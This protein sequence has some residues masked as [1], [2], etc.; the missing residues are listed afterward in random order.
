MTRTEQKERRRLQILMTG[1]DLFVSKGYH[2]TKTSDISKLAG[3]SEGLLFHYFPTKHDLYMELVKMGSQETDLFPDVIENPYDILYNAI[4]H[5]LTKIESNRVIAKMFALMNQAQNKEGTPEEIYKL[6]CT[7]STIT[8]TI[9][10][11]EL[12]QNQG[13]FREGDPLNL[14]YTFWNAFDGNM[15]ELAKNPAMEIPKAEW[16]MGILIK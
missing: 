15:L 3:I 12:G 2:A 13:V 4:N 10:I 1:L 16:L 8:D 6:A 5:F 7:V 9:K 14:S 11:I